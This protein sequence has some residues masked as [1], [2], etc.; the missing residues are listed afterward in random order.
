MIEIIQYTK[1]QINDTTVDTINPLM[2]FAKKIRS[3]IGLKKRYWMVFVNRSSIKTLNPMLTVKHAPKKGAVKEN[4]S[5]INF[6]SSRRCPNR[7]KT[8]I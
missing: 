1:N 3:Y 6:F 4:K 2:L 7:N 5:M 8:P